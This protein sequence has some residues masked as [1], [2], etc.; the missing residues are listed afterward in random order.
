VIFVLCNAL[1]IV[2][3]AWLTLEGRPRDPRELSTPRAL[4]RFLL[5]GGLLAPAI[6]ALVGSLLL[7]AL[8]GGAL[9]PVFAGWFSADALGLLT[10]V[11]LCA[12]TT[13]DELAAAFRRPKLKETLFFLVASAALTAGLLSADGLEWAILLSPVVLGAALRLGRFGGA[14]ATLAVTISGACVFAFGQAPLGHPGQEPTTFASSR[15]ASSCVLSAS[16]GRRALPGGLCER[17]A[18]PKLLRAASRAHDPD[19]GLGRGDR[20]REPGGSRLLRIRP[21][22][23]PPMRIWDIDQLGEDA[24]RAAMGRIREGRESELRVPPARGRADS[25]DEGRV[26]PDRASTERCSS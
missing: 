25:A 22:G 5:L 21:D 4:L 20:R 26:E 9:W 10:I 2:L 24:V 11:P 23:A 15:R 1:E 7:R 3:A 17:A 8:H 6:A 13:A 16:P 12:G 18:F 19:P 14:L